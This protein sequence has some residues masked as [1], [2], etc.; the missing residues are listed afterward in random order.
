[1]GCTVDPDAEMLKH[2][3]LS[4]CVKKQRT[5]RQLPENVLQRNDIA[6]SATSATA[7]SSQ[8][9]IS[10]GEGASQ[11]TVGEERNNSST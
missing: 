9:G 10:L 4:L 1:M 2:Q 7:F 11:M 6:R 8:R 3:C 5:P